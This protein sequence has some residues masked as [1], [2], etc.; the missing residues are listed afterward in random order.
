MDIELN[1]ESKKDILLQY[2]TVEEDGEKLVDMLEAHSIQN[3][4]FKKGV[5][6]VLILKDVR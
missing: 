4:Q 5:K 1:Y 3:I 6:V 2:Y